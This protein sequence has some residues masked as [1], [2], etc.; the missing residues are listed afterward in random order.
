MASKFIEYDLV[1]CTVCAHIIANGAYDDDT[2]AAEKAAAGMAE[3]WGADARHLSVT[4]GGADHST[5]RCG[6]C[7]DTDHGERHNAVCLIPREEA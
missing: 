7:G 1:M 5:A 3:I 6:G 4:E 2:D